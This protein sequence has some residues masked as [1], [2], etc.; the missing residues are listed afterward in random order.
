MSEKVSW[1]L[2]MCAARSISAL[3][4][5]ENAAQTCR[6]TFLGHDLSRHLGSTSL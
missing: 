2:R 4:A 3:E 1:K 6:D 5:E